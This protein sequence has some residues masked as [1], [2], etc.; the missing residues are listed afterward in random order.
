MTREGMVEAEKAAKEF[1]RACL[2][3][4]RVAEQRAGGDYDKDGFSGV[5]NGSAASGN[6]RRKSMDLTRVLA[7]LCSSGCV[8]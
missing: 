1:L 8:V 5:F 3:C 4:R 7:Y 6:L 2:E